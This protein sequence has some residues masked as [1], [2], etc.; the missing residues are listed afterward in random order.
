VLFRSENAPWYS[1]SHVRERVL[2]GEAMPFDHVNTPTLPVNRAL[3]HETV[4]L[5]PRN[6]VGLQVDRACNAKPA[7][8]GESCGFPGFRHDSAQYI[9]S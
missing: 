6:A 2:R 1:C 4:E 7:D 9:T 8:D 5:G 3:T